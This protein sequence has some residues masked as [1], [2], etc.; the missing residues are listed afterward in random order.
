MGTVRQASRA[1]L[2]RQQPDQ[3]LLPSDDHANPKFEPS[4]VSDQAASQQHDEHARHSIFPAARKRKTRRQRSM[5]R[6]SH[7]W[8]QPQQP[9]SSSTN[10]YRVE[11]VAMPKT[12]AAVQTMLPSKYPSR[13]KSGLAT[14]SDGSHPS[15][16]SRLPPEH[17]VT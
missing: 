5:L 3:E 17:F 2:N 14:E 6:T 13:T 7:R 1:A 10:S 9:K 15:L 8:R 4:A 12:P 16:P 11:F